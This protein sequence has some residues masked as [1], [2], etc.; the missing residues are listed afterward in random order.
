MSEDKAK[1][2]T[3]NLKPDATLVMTCE[4]AAPM[5][6]LSVPTVRSWAKQGLIPAICGGGR[7]RI[8]RKAFDRMMEDGAESLKAPVVEIDYER[9]GEEIAKAQARL[10]L[11]P[12]V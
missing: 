5:L 12:S 6:N 11:R 8:I 7:T 1:Y 3:I 4:E 10:I 9:L 2:E